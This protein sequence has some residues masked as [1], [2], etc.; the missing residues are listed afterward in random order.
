M[1]LV[2]FEFYLSFSQVT[3]LSLFNVK[4]KGERI[5]Y[6]VRIP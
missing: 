2:G 4:F 1:E 6:E 3:S 5:L